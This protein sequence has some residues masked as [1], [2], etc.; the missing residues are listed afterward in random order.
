MYKEER[1]YLAPISYASFVCYPWPHLGVFATRR[2]LSCLV[3]YW[4]LFTE[5]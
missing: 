5:R 3:K 4:Y 2:G 1:T